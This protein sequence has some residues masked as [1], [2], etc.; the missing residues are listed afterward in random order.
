MITWE[1]K[2]KKKKKK[3]LLK[4]IVSLALVW[5]GIETEDLVV[6]AGAPPAFRLPLS[7]VKSKSQEEE[8]Q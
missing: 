7:A 8:E 3:T 5:C 1:M 2:K 6:G 4:E